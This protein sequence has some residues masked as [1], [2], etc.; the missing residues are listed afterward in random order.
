M[1]WERVADRLRGEMDDVRIEVQEDQVLLQGDGEHWVEGGERLERAKESV[2]DV[3]DRYDE[4]GMRVEKV[5]DEPLDR[6][7]ICV[8]ESWRADEIEEK[9]EMVGGRDSE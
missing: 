2:R 1:D 9:E 6:R 7:Q 5:W 4:I 8:M 3:I